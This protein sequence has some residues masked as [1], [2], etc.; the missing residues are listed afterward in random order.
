MTMSRIQWNSH[1]YYF[2]QMPYSAAIPC[3]ILRAR[4]YNQ[5]INFISCSEFLINAI[6]WQILAS[7]DCDRILL[8]IQRQYGTAEKGA[9]LMFN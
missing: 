2:F 9:H 8:K 4:C 7:V 1:Y 3:A 5:E 6:Y